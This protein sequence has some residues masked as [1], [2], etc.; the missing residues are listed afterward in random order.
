VLS[1]GCLPLEFFEKQFR[2]QV[3]QLVPQAHQLQALNSAILFEY[4][5]QALT[6]MH[7]GEAPWIMEDTEGVRG[8]AGRGRSTI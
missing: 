4:P 3:W 5:K 2:W 8:N 1:E 7:Q 6:F